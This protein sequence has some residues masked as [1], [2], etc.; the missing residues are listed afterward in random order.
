MNMNMQPISGLTNA[1]CGEWKIGVTMQE[2]KEPEKT[3]E[4]SVEINSAKPKTI[5]VLEVDQWTST[6]NIKD[7]SM[8][9]FTLNKVKGGDSEAA[10]QIFGGYAAVREVRESDSPSIGEVWFISDPQS[11]RLKFFK[12]NYDS[13]D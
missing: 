6:G 12:A 11:H 2:K 3:A 5:T 4:D 10:K 8:E 13:S 9:D 7:F 1:D